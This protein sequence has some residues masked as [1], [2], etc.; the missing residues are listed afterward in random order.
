MVG[1]ARN[2][3]FI[4]GLCFDYLVSDNNKRIAVNDLPKLIPFFMILE[5]QFLIGIHVNDLHC[6]RLIVGELLKLPPRS[7]FRVGFFHGVSVQYS[8][9]LSNNP[10][11]LAI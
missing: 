6:G 3:V 7:F 8:C 2:K 9:F 1:V 10:I 5:T 4:P 11:E